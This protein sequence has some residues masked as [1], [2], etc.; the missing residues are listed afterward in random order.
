MK[1]RTQAGGASPRF[2]PPLQ[3]IAACILPE[4]DGNIHGGAAA[5]GVHRKLLAGFRAL[6]QTEPQILDALLA[7]PDQ[8]QAESLVLTFGNYG[9]NLQQNGRTS[10][11]QLA[12]R[13]SPEVFVRLYL[14]SSKALTPAL[15]AL[16]D[17]MLERAATMNGDLGSAFTCHG[18]NNYRAK[19]SAFF[20]GI[21]P[22]LDP[23]IIDRRLELN[24]GLLTELA[25]CPQ[26]DGQYR[27]S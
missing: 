14:S 11:W 20:P 9:G 23:R 6:R 27:I 22:S 15:C 25:A 1:T 21:D 2:V 12:R 18:R 24:V 10:K 8:Q 3:R 13:L 17:P 7:W 19:P 16:P 4:G 5:L 26:G